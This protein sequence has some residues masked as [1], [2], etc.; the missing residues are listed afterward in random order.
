MNWS[1]STD[2]LQHSAWRV[3]TAEQLVLMTWLPAGLEGQGTPEDW[4]QACR[5]PA[6][7]RSGK[8][9]LSDG[10][11]HLLLLQA[12]GRVQPQPQRG[13]TQLTLLV[14]STAQADDNHLECHEWTPARKRA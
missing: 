6:P 4:G 14:I 2:I 3:C 12:P 8:M 7:P 13:L 9:W 5:Q 1:Y 10:I 11:G